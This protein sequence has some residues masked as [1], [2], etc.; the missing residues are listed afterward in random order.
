MAS[1]PISAGGN[2][3][4]GAGS[5]TEA[6]L[7]ARRELGLLAVAGPP[8]RTVLRQ[9]TSVSTRPMPEFGSDL[10]ERRSRSTVARVAAPKNGMHTACSL[11]ERCTE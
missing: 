6:S 1:E 11:P 3:P 8:V 2:M 7:F 4:S 5:F 10:R 9:L